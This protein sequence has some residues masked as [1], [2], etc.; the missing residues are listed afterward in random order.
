MGK[1]DK[2]LIVMREDENGRLVVLG[3]IS[4]E[5]FNRIKEI[6]HQESIDKRTDRGMYP[7]H[8]VDDAQPNCS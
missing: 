5:H 2:E 1:A 4:E 3:M 7:W 6:E 8:N